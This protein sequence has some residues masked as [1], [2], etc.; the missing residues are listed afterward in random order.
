MRMYIYNIK[1]QNF[2]KQK[3]I[4]IYSWLCMGYNLAI[5]Y[6]IFKDSKDIHAVLRRYNTY[7]G[8][9]YF[10]LVHICVRAHTHTHT[11]TYT[12]SPL[13]FS[14]NLVVCLLLQ[15]FPT[16]LGCSRRGQCRVNKVQCLGH[17]K[18]INVLSVTDFKTI[19]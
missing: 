1:N 12:H 5:H 16:I 19:G 14:R 8:V 17:T 9:G 13:R 3:V 15:Q 6:W 7:V 4:Q 10:V 18:L 2:I 11:N